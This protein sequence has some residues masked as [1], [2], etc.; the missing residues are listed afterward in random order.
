MKENWRPFCLGE[1]QGVGDDSCF[2]CPFSF[3]CEKLAKRR[4]EME[5]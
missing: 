4:K 2:D 5:E 3:E 1:Y